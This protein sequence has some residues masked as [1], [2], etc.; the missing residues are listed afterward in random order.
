MKQKGKIRV[1]HIVPVLARGG[2]EQLLYDIL[3]RLDMTR[4][5]TSICC[6]H[7]VGDFKQHERFNAVSIR[8]RVLPY[9]DSRL[10]RVLIMYKYL[11]YA[12]FD[13]VHIHNYE[14]NDIYARIAAILAR[15][16]ITMTYDHI[17]Y[18]CWIT[19]RNKWMW[20]VLNLFT[21]RNVVISRSVSE[22][23]L[24]CCGKQPRKV[25]TITNGVDVDFFQPRLKRYS[26]KVKV[27]LGIDQRKK[28][29][30]AIGR[31]IPLKRF[32]LLV[33][34]AAYLKARGDVEFVLGGDGPLETELKNLT[35]SLGISDRFHFLGWQPDIQRIYQALDIF[36]ATS[37]VAEGFGLVVVEAMAMGIPVVAVNSPTYSEVLSDCGILVDPEPKR[38]AEAIRRLIEDENFAATL[39]K[40][41]RTR[42]KKFFNI[43]RTAKELSDLYLET[44]AKVR[45]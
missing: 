45:R 32:D 14:G 2:T 23:R 26:A 18:P 30:G 20:Q 34:S 38:I 9:S 21:D 37:N 29:V 44:Y 8:T 5:E 6:T 16:P 3:S 15:V 40:K 41:G 27:S 42:V 35:E 36:V 25:T 31:L 12:K 24:K 39:A 4:F 22:Y 7:G 10:R 43:E 13:I 19:W 1:L 17:I 11:I 28:V 33:K